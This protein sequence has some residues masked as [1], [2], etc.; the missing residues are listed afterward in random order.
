MSDENRQ[1]GLD[2]LRVFATLAVMVLHVAAQNWSVTDVKGYAWQTFNFYDSLVRWGVPAFLMISG[3]LFLGREIPTKRIYTKYILRIVTAFIVWSGFYAVVDLLSGED[4]KTAIGHFIAGKYHMWYLFMI[5]GIYICIP[6]IKVIV[7]N[8]K[9]MEYF[10]ILSFLFAF[11]FP[12]IV[13]IANDFAPA[14]LAMLFNYINSDVKTM[15]ME[16]VMGYSFYFV[17]GYYLNNKSLKKCKNVICILGLLGFASTIILSSIISI[18]RGEATGDYYGNFTVN[19]LLESVMIFTLFKEAKFQNK[20]INQIMVKLSKYSFGAYLVHVFVIAFLIKIGINTLTFNTTVS[21][22][23]IAIIVFVI[24]FL[25]SCV[26]NHIP[27]I[28]KYIV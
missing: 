2:Y 23:V 3:C 27:F 28:N 18:K 12:E 21:V 11:V 25:I 24:S 13:M 9:A 26:L 14:E 8:E 16:L 22:P 4:L 5:V 1:V 6:V 20:K 19:I 7:N 15:H 10:L 17:L